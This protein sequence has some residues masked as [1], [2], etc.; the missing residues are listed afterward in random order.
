MILNQSFYNVDKQLKS[1]FIVEAYNKKNH[2]IISIYSKC[3]AEL[4][5]LA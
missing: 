2:K 4:E 1:F 3:Y 5:F